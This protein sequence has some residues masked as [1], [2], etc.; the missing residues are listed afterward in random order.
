MEIPKEKVLEL[1]RSRGDQ[2]KADQADQEL[3]DNVDPER[4]S[5]L[6]SKFGVEPSDLLGKFGGGKIP[7][8]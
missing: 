4:D 7:G 3:P 1:L 2:D 6:L 8:L 5:G